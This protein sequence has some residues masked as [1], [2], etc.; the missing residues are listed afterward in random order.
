MTLLI[1]GPQRFTGFF[2]WTIHLT[3][4]NPGGFF[5]EVI[6]MAE[7]AAW[8]PIPI[9]GH[10][11][12]LDVTNIAG[13]TAG[14]TKQGV[15]YQCFSLDLDNLLPKS[16]LSITA[17]SGPV[18][19]GTSPVTINNLNLHLQTPAGSQV[20]NSLNIGGS[21]GKNG[22][23]MDGDA[24]ASPFSGVIGTMTFKNWWTSGVDMGVPPIPQP[25]TCG[26]EFS[27]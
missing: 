10:T 3:N 9:V 6:L 19:A 15:I 11:F 20:A 26:N 21:G 18:Q 2:Y 23:T 27:L 5:A 16:S 8:K 12:N 7:L 17:T 4:P 1:R 22:V 25:A 24:G 14:S 13:I